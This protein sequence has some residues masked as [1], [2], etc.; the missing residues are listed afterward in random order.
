[1]GDE[2]GSMRQMGV[3]IRDERKK[4]ITNTKPE[5]ELAQ[6]VKNESNSVFCISGSTNHKSPRMQASM[7]HPASC[8]GSSTHG[9]KI[10]EQLLPDCFTW[11]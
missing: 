3:K 1:M 7:Y 10:N 4:H 9:R 2:G 6:P 8:C 11:L 5:H